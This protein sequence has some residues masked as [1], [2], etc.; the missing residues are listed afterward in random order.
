[1]T[2]AQVDATLQIDQRIK[3]QER[4][5]DRNNVAMAFRND[6]KELTRGI[7]KDLADD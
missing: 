5:L 7:N 4:A 1:M 2:P 3:R 6:G